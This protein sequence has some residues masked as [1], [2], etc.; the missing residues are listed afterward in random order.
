MRWIREEEEGDVSITEILL[1]AILI[2][3]VLLLVFAL[4]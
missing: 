1:I 4:T 2:I 3:V